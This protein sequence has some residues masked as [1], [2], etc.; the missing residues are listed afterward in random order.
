[1]RRSV[2]RRGRDQ[3]RAPRQQ[4]A[5]DVAQVVRGVGEE[6]QRAA[7]ETGRRFDADEQ[8]VERDTDREGAMTRAARRRVGVSVPMTVPGVRVGVT[9]HPFEV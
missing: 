8:Q 2:G 4:Q 3:A 1:M 7:P 6:R 9:V 5:A